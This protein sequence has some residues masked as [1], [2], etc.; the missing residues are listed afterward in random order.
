M[1]FVEYNNFTRDEEKMKLMIPTSKLEKQL[2]KEQTGK[3][4]AIFV[5]TGSNMS[6]SVLFTS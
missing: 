6:T 2:T 4:L 5:S 1:Y 3:D